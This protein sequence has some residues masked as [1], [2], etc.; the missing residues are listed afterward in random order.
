MGCDGRP[1]SGD[2]PSAISVGAAAAVASLTALAAV[3]AIA[4]AAILLRFRKRPELLYQAWDEAI[5]DHVT[6]LAEN[7]IYDGTEDTRNPLFDMTSS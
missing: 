2:C 7:P 6:A 1:F 5:K 4:L 3:S